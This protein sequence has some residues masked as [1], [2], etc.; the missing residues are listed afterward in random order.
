MKL[1]RALALGICLASLALAAQTPA[2]SADAG[3]AKPEVKGAEP[4]A[5]AAAATPAGVRPDSPCKRDIEAFCANVQAGGGRIYKCLA[6]KEAELSSNCKKR[7]AVLRETGGEC[8][9]DIEKFCADVPRGAGRL[10]QCL[11]EH[12]AELSEGCKNLSVPKA[13]AAPTGAAAPAAA[14]A[15]AAAAAPAD[16]GAQAADAGPR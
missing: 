6:E 5:G 2:P 15:P 12:H 16:A 10:A 7:L 1:D 14:K 4:A 8:K 13:A 11:S 3:T 9:D